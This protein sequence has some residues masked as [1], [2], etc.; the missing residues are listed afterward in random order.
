MLL[1]F[2]SAQKYSVVLLFLC[3]TW[4]GAAT[5]QSDISEEQSAE[6]VT[7]KQ[8]RI[9]GVVENGTERFLGIPYAMPP[10]GERRWKV[11]APIAPH[12]GILEANSFGPAC[13]QPDNPRMPNLVMNEDCLTLNVWRPETVESP[14]PVMVWI[15]GGGFVGGNSH[16]PGEILAEQ[17]V[18]VVSL[19][20]RLGPLGFFAH[21]ALNSDVANYGLTD[22]IQALQWLQDNIAAFHGDPQNITIFGVSAG[23]MM[24]DLLLASKH[25]DGLFQKAI[26]QSGYITWP[27]PTTQN[28]QDK[29]VLDINNQPTVSAEMAGAALVEPILEKGATQKALHSLSAIQLVKLVTGFHRPIV[30][31]NTIEDQPYRL[32][33]SRSENVAL[34]TGGN[35]FEGSIMPHSGISMIDYQQTWSGQSKQLQQLY[36]DDYRKSP[37]LA[38]SRAFGDERY[39]LAAYYLG[40]AWQKKEAPVW[41]Y[42]NDLAPSAGAPGT[43]HGM[44]QYLIFHG[45]K[46]PSSE[47]KKLGDNLRHYWINFAKQGNPNGAELPVWPTYTDANHQWL[48]LD[49]NTAPDSVKAEVMSVLYQRVLSR[50]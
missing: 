49:K 36:A 11:A 13:V 14:L 26:A 7:L 38:Y 24:V 23:G 5:A 40:Q 31:G 30:D 41:L 44:D 2:F 1:R 50:E 27:L 35:S 33:G 29:S 18:I 12:Q 46:I 34:I 16:I 28:E 3:V 37:E 22:A 15:H 43:P 39:L 6:I 48:K 21:P 20:Y 42:Y 17:G 9:S 25:A 45:D 19:N 32:V 4:I 10:V 47:L 8:G